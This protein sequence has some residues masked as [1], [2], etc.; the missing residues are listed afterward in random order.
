MFH[1]K[2]SGVRRK[3]SDAPFMARR[4]ELHSRIIFVERNRRQH[5]YPR[6]CVAAGTSW[7][8]F[9][10]I[11]I[12]SLRV[13]HAEYSLPAAAAFHVKQSRVSALRLRGS[14]ECVA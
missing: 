14:P 6:C 4:Y 8:H 7:A 12:A 9:D 1:V 13:F 10:R 11:Q 5:R 3:R 2:R